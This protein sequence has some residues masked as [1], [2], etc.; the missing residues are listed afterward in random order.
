MESV[1]VTSQTRHGFSHN[2][3][4]QRAGTGGGKTPGPVPGIEIEQV[5]I[6]VRA[7]R[8]PDRDTERQAVVCGDRAARAAQAGGVVMKALTRVGEAV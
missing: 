6:P 7:E 1:R 3:I 8:A 4:R 2:P 5:D